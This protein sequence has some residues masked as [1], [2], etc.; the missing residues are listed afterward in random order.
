MGNFIRWALIGALTAGTLT[1]AGFLVACHHEMFT[2]DSNEG[3]AWTWFAAVMGTLGFT[4]IGFVLGGI[5]GVIRAHKA[6]LLKVIGWSLTGAFIGEIVAAG[7]FLCVRMIVPSMAAD[8]MW[9]GGNDP[10]YVGLYDAVLGFVLGSAYRISRA[11]IA[12]DP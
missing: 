5:Y 7:L 1:F 9:N 8:A 10:M 3:Q 6:P 12:A 11:R 4:V 2:Q